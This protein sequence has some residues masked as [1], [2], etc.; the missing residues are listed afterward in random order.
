MYLLN[1]DGIFMVTQNGVSNSTLCDYMYSV[2]VY[3][4]LFAIFLPSYLLTFIW[5]T[6]RMWES[7]IS[8]IIV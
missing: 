5:I 1:L 8:L 2:C 3:M 6:G 4:N 7:P